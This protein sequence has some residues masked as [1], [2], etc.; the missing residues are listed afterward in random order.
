MPVA[1]GVLAAMAV[2][3]TDSGHW[4]VRMAPRLD[5]AINKAM[6]A[7][8]EKYG[9]CSMAKAQVSADSYGCL[10]IVR[11]ADRRNLVVSAGGTLGEAIR[12]AREQMTD[13]GTDGE[14][15]FRKCNG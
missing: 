8:A 7:C 4:V 3:W 1:G 6:A 11:G 10:V 2:S 13:A 15:V 9:E 12:V 5:V 14:I